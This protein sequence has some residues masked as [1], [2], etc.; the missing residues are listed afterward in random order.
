MRLPRSVHLLKQPHVEG[1]H[2][3]KL[4]IKIALWVSE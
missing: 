1:T 4:I 2:S 3:M